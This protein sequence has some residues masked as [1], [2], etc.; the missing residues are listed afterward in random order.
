VIAVIQCTAA[1]LC[2]ST[3]PADYVVGPLQASG[4]FDRIVIASPALGDMPRLQAQ[5]ANWDIPAYFGHDYDVGQ[6]LLAACALVAPGLPAHAIVVRVILRRFYID[7]ALVRRMIEMIEAGSDYV[8]L[9]NDINYE[10][11]ADVCTLSALQRTV[12]LLD[13]RQEQAYATANYR[14]YPWRL[15]EDDPAF[16]VARIDHIDAWPREKSL[17]IRE[18]LGQLLA[19]A[20]EN[21]VAV[22][23]LAGSGRYRFILDWIKPK[24][25]VADIACGQGGGCRILAERAGA[26][27][28]I[29]T[30]GHYIDAANAANNDPRLRFIQGSS[31]RLSADGPHFDAIV[32]M[33]TL[34]HVDEPLQFLVNIRKALRPGGVLI[35]EVPRLLPLPLGMPLFPFHH[36]EYRPESLEPLLMQAGFD[37]TERFGGN[38]GSYGPIATA[39]EVML[40]LCRP[41][42]VT[43]PIHPT[44]LPTEAR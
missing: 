20:G 18:R 29:D 12:A 43:G 14:F 28:G 5:A 7:L 6:R 37:I 30:N 1:D 21:Q 31:D 16:H 41:G 35:L 13:A 42:G 9:G 4:L 11:A 2:A 39:R 27:L 19:Q 32:S 33:H 36:I 3:D 26:V 22:D 8:T 10:V 40:Y 38:R 23:P 34:E 25:E 15:M 24:S 44:P 17:E